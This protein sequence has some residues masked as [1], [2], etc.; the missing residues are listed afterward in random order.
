MLQLAAAVRRIISMPQHIISMLQLR[1]WN[2][3]EVKIG[4]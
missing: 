3:Q 2:G 1:R 4:I